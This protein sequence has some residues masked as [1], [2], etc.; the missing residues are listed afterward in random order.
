VSKRSADGDSPSGNEDTEDNNEDTTTD[1]NQE[2]DDA[3]IENTAD[4]EMDTR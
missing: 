2:Q 3:S 1:I 4:D